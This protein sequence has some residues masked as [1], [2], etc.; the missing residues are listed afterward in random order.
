MIGAGAQVMDGARVQRH[1]VLAP[2]GILSMKKVIPSGQMWAGVPAIYLRYTCTCMRVYYISIS[3]HIKNFFD[4]MIYTLIFTYVNS[5]C[6]FS[7][8]CT[9]ACVSVRYTVLFIFF[10]LSI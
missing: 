1:G 2:G 8:L 7:P 4:D 5:N 10:Y 3:V 6:I 9:H